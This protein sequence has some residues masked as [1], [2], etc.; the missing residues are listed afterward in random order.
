VRRRHATLARNL[1]GICRTGLLTSKSQGKLPAVWLC[2]APKTLWVAIH[3]T[4]R[5]GGRID[6][7]VVLEI[8]VPR[9]WLRRSK[10][11]LY[12]CR[13]DIPPERPPRGR[14]LRR[15][16]PV[17]GGRDDRPLNNGAEQRSGTRSAPT[18]PPKKRQAMFENA[19]VIHRSIRA[20]AIAE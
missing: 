1:P 9:S 3:V 8:D 18:H 6:N 19:E 5:H 12:Y 11:G 2:S 13:R 16:G 15:A 10:R 20:Q 7:V 4:R 14:H 17:P